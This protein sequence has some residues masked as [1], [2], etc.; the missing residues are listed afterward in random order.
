MFFKKYCTRI[1]ISGPTIYFVDNSEINIMGVETD[2][3]A[4]TQDNSELF[5]KVGAGSP[6]P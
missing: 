6:R 2:C 3:F 4:P 1:K 5:V